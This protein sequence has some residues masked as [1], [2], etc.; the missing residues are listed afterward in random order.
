MPFGA[1]FK[2][3]ATGF[4]LTLSITAPA[5]LQAQRPLPVLR[6][7]PGGYRDP[8]LAT[9]FSVLVAGGGQFY[10]GRK[11]KGALLLA[12]TI[13]SALISIDGATPCNTNAPP[14]CGNSS[15]ETLGLAG[16]I[17]F[18]AYGWATAASDARKHN[19]DLT[20]GSTGLAP[21]LDLHDGRT[22]AGLSLVLR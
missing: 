11:G 5:A 7:L 9:A 22:L 10:V 21:F 13:T 12:G 19:D 18:W 16:A 8:R 2:R 1:Y 3:F 15:A 20:N 17:A 14:I 4:A 6:P